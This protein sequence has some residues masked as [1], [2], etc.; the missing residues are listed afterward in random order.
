M[1]TTLLSPSYS[2]IQSLHSA[3]QACNV[4]NCLWHDILLVLQFESV[5]ETVNLMPVRITGPEKDSG[6]P[7]GLQ[8]PIQSALKEPLL[9][10]LNQGPLKTGKVV[11]QAVK[12]YTSNADGVM[13]ANATFIQPCPV[14][15]FEHA[16]LQQLR[17]Y[18]ST[19][20]S[21]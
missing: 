18:V 6:L 16:F 17:S 19:G 5:G 8:H 7:E 4:T 13:K 10:G 21:V 11:F 20:S 12:V 3:E 1:I 2:T 15:L 9:A 14:L